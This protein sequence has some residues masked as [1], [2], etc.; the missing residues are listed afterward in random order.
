MEALDGQYIMK[1][2]NG[3]IFQV[4]ASILADKLTDIIKN[5]MK[6]IGLQSYQLHIK[7]KYLSYLYEKHIQLSIYG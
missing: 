2:F 5:R 4:T 6:V 7:V 1:F 3:E